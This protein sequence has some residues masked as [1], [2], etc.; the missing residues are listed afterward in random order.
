METIPLMISPKPSKLESKRPFKHV[1]GSIGK[2]ASWQ[3]AV[4]FF[5]GYDFFISYAWIDGLV[6][7]EK[8]AKNLQD[9]GFDCFL[10]SE[11]FIKG[12]DWKV[13]GAAAIR[14]TSNLVLVG[15]PQAL[16]SD[17]VKLEIEIFSSSGRRIIPIDFDGSLDASNLEG[18]PLAKFILPNMLRIK[19]TPQSL[20]NGPSD[21]TINDLQG[22]F[23][24]IRQS[25][26]RGR[27]LKAVAAVLAVS[28]V[29]SLGFWRLA[30]RR[31]KAADASR[32]AAIIS[33]EN[34]RVAKQT[35]VKNAEQADIQRGLAEKQKNIA[36][37]NQHKADIQRGLAEKQKHIA[38]DNQ[39]QAEVQR[40]LAIGRRILAEAEALGSSGISENAVPRA[41]LAATSVGFFRDRVGAESSDEMREAIAGLPSRLLHLRNI[42]GAVFTR[43]P[44]QLATIDKSGMLIVWDL[45]KRLALKKHLC[46]PT[47][48]SLAYDANHNLLVTLSPDR[49]IALWDAVSLETIRILKAPFSGQIAVDPKGHYAMENL[50]PGRSRPTDAVYSLLDLD[51]GKITSL[52]EADAIVEQVL[53]NNDGTRLAVYY[54]TKDSVVHIELRDAFSQRL[55]LGVPINE[56]DLPGAGATA[57]HIFFSEDSSLFMIGTAAEG[58]QFWNSKTGTPSG[59]RLGGRPGPVALTSRY[60]ATVTPTSGGFELA[61][62]GPR[63]PTKLLTEAHLRDFQF[64]PTGQYLV[65]HGG[66]TGGSIGYTYVW[67]ALN[68]WERVSVD[69]TST[70]LFSPSGALLA[71]INAVDEL[72]VW[73]LNDRRATDFVSDS[74]E[75]ALAHRSDGTTIAGANVKPRF[76]GSTGADPGDSYTPP[77]HSR[78]CY[79]LLRSGGGSYQTT[80]GKWRIEKNGNGPMHI[81]NTDANSKPVYIPG[82]TASVA[83]SAKENT[84]AY[85]TDSPPSTGSEAVAHR[86]TLHIISTFPR[87]EERSCSIYTSQFAPISITPSLGLI[88]VKKLSQLAIVDPKTCT[89]FSPQI[90]DAIDDVVMSSD[91]RKVA[92]TT[93]EGLF[94]YDIASGQMLL[95]VKPLPL[96]FH[97]FAFRA[98]GK[99][100]ALSGKDTSGDTHLYVYTL[101]ARS[102]LEEVCTR[103]HRGGLSENEWHELVDAQLPLQSTCANASALHK[104]FDDER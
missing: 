36:E 34:E 63:E 102:L 81:S 6:Y 68:W 67:D 31:Q 48:S 91:D 89:T 27:A 59:A 21:A 38:E 93:Q 1:A 70:T 74:E 92:F 100:V 4:D 73:N 53:F 25:V 79:E 42:S 50:S 97:L 20:V 58:L 37:D 85:L 103:V 69:D 24:N 7:A 18:C 96:G 95:H 71:G 10:D 65:A 75:V 76:R 3:K 8:L 88:V 17:P 66:S 51:S 28:L 90:G 43:N 30:V 99:A 78:N 94:V 44:N 39:H 16:Q 56:Q 32:A 9:R 82:D 104:E 80:D 101:E 72:S 45:T 13:T 23:A 57:A 49:T 83:L 86:S 15:S 55:I 2:R 40:D 62:G 84:L 64:S 77:P 29:I 61:G 26:K 19:E 14:R 22:T 11:S 52:D 47:P 87:S 60:K 35:A 12:D 33:A 5:F 98:D 41:L 46:S 54:K